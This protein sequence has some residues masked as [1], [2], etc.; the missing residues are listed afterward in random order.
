[1]KR[2]LPDDMKLNRLRPCP[3]GGKSVRTAGAFYGDP[4]GPP[5]KRQGPRSARPGGRERA[6]PVGGGTARPGLATGRDQGRSAKPKC[7]R[8]AITGGRLVTA[9]ARLGLAAVVAACAVPPPELP[10]GDP[11][12]PAK[13]FSTAYPTAPARS[14]RALAQDFLELG[15]HLESGLPLEAFSRFE[16]PVSVR[17]TGAPPPSLQPD[18]DRLLDRLR[19]EAGID[20]SQVAPDHPAN[21][22]ISVIPGAWL[23]R[24]VPQAACLVAPR[25]TNW[26]DY[27]ANRN[28]RLTD[29]RT[30]H[31]RETVAIFLPGDAPPQTIR[32]CLHEEIAQALGPLNDVYRLPD[33][34]FNDDNI[35]AVLTGFDMLMLRVHYSPRL[36][37]GMSRAE[38]AAVLP[39]ILRA[40]NPGGEG[41][42]AAP[43]LASP[44]AWRA[45]MAQALTPGIGTRQR[46]RAIGTALDIARAQGWND[47]RTA[48]ALSVQGRVLARRDPV[49]SLNSFLEAHRIYATRP[50]TQLHAAHV[51]A[52]LAVFALADNDPEQALS[53]VGRY[54]G[55]AE[56]A[57]N[58]VLLST[59]LVV[60]AEALR[61]LG[62]EDEAGAVLQSALGWARYG[63]GSDTA[64][65]A[66]VGEIVQVARQA[67]CEVP[68]CRGKGGRQ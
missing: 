20:I 14:N 2:I 23:R 18:L 50:E 3:D 35:H 60:R 66:Y 62:R 53:I 44:K 4:C 37:S 25:V 10:G 8:L 59:L 67:S 27:R 39:G 55:I 29:W 45:A 7:S 34:V 26:R 43:V 48:F 1:M 38:V 32:D 11:L 40:L 22:T 47:N 31:M 56:R 9:L 16:G 68:R 5:G 58:A 6:A 42:P 17:V 57:E 51:A 52:D 28:R 41:R 24:V 54:A 64:V 63:F 15:F 12:P 46:A 30:L 33:S 13:A 61:A 21:I 65:R 36:R 49:R 19:R